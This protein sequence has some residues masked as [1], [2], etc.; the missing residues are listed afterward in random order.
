MGT[1]MPL[2][3][4]GMKWSWHSA[5]L[6]VR[7]GRATLHNESY[8]SMIFAKLELLKFGHARWHPIWISQHLVWMSS[9]QL[10]Q[11]MNSWRPCAWPARH[12]CSVFTFLFSSLTQKPQKT[13]CNNVIIE[14]YNT[15]GIKR[16]WWHQ[17]SFPIL[18]FASF[19][20]RGSTFSKK[21]HLTVT[22]IWMVYRRGPYLVQNWSDPILIKGLLSFQACFSLAIAFNQSISSRQRSAIVES[23][24]FEINPVWEEGWHFASTYSMMEQDGH[25][26]PPALKRASLDVERESV[27]MDG[28]EAIGKDS[29]HGVNVKTGFYLHSHTVHPLWTCGTHCKVVTPSPTWNGRKHLQHASHFVLWDCGSLFESGVV[30][31]KSQLKK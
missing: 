4:A 11:M 26:E 31:R 9:H 16:G 30:E 3:I 24:I 5:F 18:N 17:L 10:S 25:S 21:Y 23:F 12:H 20:V 22:N 2:K 1:H 8:W 29:I 28:L 15:T 19:G 13:H 7:N 27:D 6:G 14:I